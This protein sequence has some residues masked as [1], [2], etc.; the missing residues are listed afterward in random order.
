M[1]QKFINPWD[2][3]QAITGSVYSATPTYASGAEVGLAVYTAPASKLFTPGIGAPARHENWALKALG[4]LAVQGLQAQA[5]QFQS[6]KDW[7]TGKIVSACYARANK[8]FVVQTSS[9]V[10]IS[11]DGKHT[12]A[13]FV[14]Q[15]ASTLTARLVHDDGFHVLDLEIEPGV[16]SKVFSLSSSATTQLA[17]GNDFYPNAA[18]TIGSGTTSH[19]LLVGVDLVPSVQAYTYSG[20]ATTPATSTVTMPSGSFPTGTATQW[21]ACQVFRGATTAT[22]PGLIYS[23]GDS[24]KNYLKTT[25][26]A[27]LTSGTMTTG[28]GNRLADI[29]YDDVQS[30]FVAALYS[31]TGSVVK[32]ATSPDGVTWTNSTTATGPASFT[33]GSGIADGSVAFTICAGVWIL[34]ATNIRFPNSIVEQLDPPV[35]AV[36]SGDF[37]VTWQACQVDM[38][39]S[40]GATVRLIKTPN[41]VAIKTDS[42]IAVSG[43]IG[44]NELV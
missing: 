32:F 9:T 41:Q 42:D 24:T 8:G 12:N 31:S 36:W 30:L 22:G 17:Q 18:L 10:T 6:A 27:T 23:R 26:G 35:S 21:G 15:T 28:I 5:M 11:R 43:V 33:V 1:T 29:S 2:A 44:Y 3:T 7:T 19:T 25:D 34:A 37:G 14:T 40:T 16:G 39:S 20:T 13:M 38:F 4:D